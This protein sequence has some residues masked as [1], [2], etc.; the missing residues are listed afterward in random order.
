VRTIW[1]LTASGGMPRPLK[2][3]ARRLWSYEQLIVW[4]RAGC[5]ETGNT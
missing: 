1:S 3:R 4:I 2:V 5:P